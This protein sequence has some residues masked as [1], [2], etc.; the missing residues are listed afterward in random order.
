[1]MASLGVDQTGFKS[2]KSPSIQFSKLDR[3][4]EA[5]QDED[6]FKDRTES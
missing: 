1:M 2:P 5:S 3:I 4:N 6:A